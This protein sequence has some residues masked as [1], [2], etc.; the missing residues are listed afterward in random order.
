MIFFLQDGGPA[1][2]YV[3]NL[4]VKPVFAPCL[5]PCEQCNLFL[6]VVGR[7]QG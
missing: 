3:G 4:F 1:T 6:F 5:E 7:L 2:F